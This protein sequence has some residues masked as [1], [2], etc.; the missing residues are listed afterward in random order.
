MTRPLIVLGLMVCLVPCVAWGQSKPE[1]SADLS[2]QQILRALQLDPARMQADKTI[3]A[4]GYMMAYTDGTN[5]V[6]ITRSVVTGVAVTRMKPA[7]RFQSW[8]LGK[9]AGLPE[10]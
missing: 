3:G 8:M 5:E 7:D 9:P 2:D 6:Y 1:L 10:E 4:D